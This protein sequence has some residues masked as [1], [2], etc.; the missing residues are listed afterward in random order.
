LRQS[1]H[2]YLTSLAGALM[3][4]GVGEIFAV[5]LLEGL[6]H[7]ELGP[8][9]LAYLIDPSVEALQKRLAVHQARGEMAPG[10][11]RNAALM[12]IGP[13]LLAC[14]HQKQLFGARDHPLDLPSLIGELTDAFVKSY[15]A[16]GAVSRRR[17]A[18]R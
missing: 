3:H 10:E 8:A 2:D 16:P 11:T 12:L 18:L 5:G 15:G 13:V 17:D 1:V 7:A 4:R 9:S 14:Q 6:L